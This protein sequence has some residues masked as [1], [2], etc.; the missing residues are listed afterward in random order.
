MTYVI[1]TIFLALI[2]YH[3][4]TLIMEILRDNISFNA[5]ITLILVDL[6]FI[7]MFV[8]VLLKASK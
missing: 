2:F 4:S 7:V 8:V 1:T 5:A 6:F 3:F